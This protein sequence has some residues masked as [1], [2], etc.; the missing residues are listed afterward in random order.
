M[1]PLRILVAPESSKVCI[2]VAVNCQVVAWIEDEAFVHRAFQVS[3][4]LLCC[5]LVNL[6]RLENISRTLVNCKSAVWLSVIQI[7]QHADYAQVVEAARCKAPS[8]AQGNGVCSA[9]L[10][11]GDGS[12]ELA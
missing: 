7:V 5:I 6:L 4:Y 8:I 1:R 2:G 3:T 10:A 12:C 9:G 11:T